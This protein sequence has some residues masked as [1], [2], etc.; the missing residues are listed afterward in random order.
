MW[1]WWR[2][3]KHER[4]LRCVIHHS[5]LPLLSILHLFVS[6]YSL[7]LLML[8][9]IISLSMSLFSSHHPSTQSHR[10]WMC[11]SVSIIAHKVCY[12][13]KNVS[14]GEGATETGETRWETIEQ[15]AQTGDQAAWA[16]NGQR[17]EQTHWRHVSVGPEGESQK[18]SVLFVSLN[19][20]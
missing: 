4:K 1:C 12:L 3:W 10:L 20:K 15:G 11:G 7:F 2:R 16:G 17:A 8:H 14:A 18:I 19:F 5:L 9:L 13:F 6:H